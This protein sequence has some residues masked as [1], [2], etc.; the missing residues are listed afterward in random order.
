[1]EVTLFNN[2]IFKFNTINEFYDYEDFDKIKTCIIYTIKIEKFI[3]LPENLKELF[4]N[5]NKL[6]T[7]DNLPK[8]LEKLSC[9]NNPIISINIQKSINYINYKVP[10]ILE[11]F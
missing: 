4:C 1:M 9:E 6:K 11:F 8:D 2:K 10:S 7:L 5:N 3:K